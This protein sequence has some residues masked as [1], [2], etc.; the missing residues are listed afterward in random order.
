MLRRGILEKTDDLAWA[1][2]YINKNASVNAA[3]Y[4]SGSTVVELQVFRTSHSEHAMVYCIVD[5]LQLSMI[6]D[7]INGHY[8]T[9]TGSF[10]L[11]TSPPEQFEA[12]FVYPKSNF[13]KLYLLCHLPYLKNMKKS[14]TYL[15]IKSY[16]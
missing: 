3:E 14:W 1:F 2:K 6:Y 10:R 15:F 5:Y 4:K 11:F 12:I 13:L 16:R 8:T 7:V 9:S